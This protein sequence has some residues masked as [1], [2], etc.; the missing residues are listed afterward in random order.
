MLNQE[1]KMWEPYM[2]Q[3]LCTLI[4]PIAE[5]YG[6]HVA[7][8]GGPLYKEGPRKDADILI[9]PHGSRTVELTEIDFLKMLGELSNIGITLGDRRGSVQKASW[10]IGRAVDFFPMGFSWV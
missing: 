8:T 1:T 2:A 6:A 7:L 10:G 9:Y 5:K 4:E 3:V